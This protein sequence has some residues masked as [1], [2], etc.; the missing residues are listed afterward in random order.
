MMID[1]TFFD[2]F[3]FIIWMILIVY[4]VVDLRNVKLRRWPRY[5]LFV[6]GVMGIIL[7]GL[8][9]VGLYAGWA[10]ID[11]AWMFDHLGIPVF[12]FILWLAMS[13]L[14]NRNISRPVWT[15]WFLFAIG[16]AGLLAD[17]FILAGHYGGI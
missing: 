13:D 8:L 14:K 9:L 1:P 11:S 3:G 6:I 17:G 12:L 7:D 10:F 16:I 15:K 4:A 2:H 5:V